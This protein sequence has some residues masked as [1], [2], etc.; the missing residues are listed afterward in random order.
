MM[1]P[2]EEG[3]TFKG[4]VVHDGNRNLLLDSCNNW[5]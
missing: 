1:I 4:V 5:R 2:E 3:F